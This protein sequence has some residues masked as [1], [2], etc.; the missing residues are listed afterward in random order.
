MCAD[1]DVRADVH[2]DRPTDEAEAGSETVELA[3][4]WA[5]HGA[6]V[7]LLDGVIKHVRSLFGIA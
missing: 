3:L 4:A 1:L 5:R 7:A 6:V 2:A